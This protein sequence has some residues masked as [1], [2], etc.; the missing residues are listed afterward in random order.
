V[1]DA[2]PPP[3]QRPIAFEIARGRTAKHKKYAFTCDSGATISVCNRLDIF[4]TID[5]LSPKLRVKVANGSLVTPSCTGTVRLNMVD[6]HGTPYT[7]LHKNVHYSANFSSNLLSVHEMYKQHKISTVFRGS[8]A[9][10]TTPDDV[11]IPIDFTPNRQYIL[12]ANA[13]SIDGASAD[14]VHE[15][16]HK[17][18][19]H[20]GNGTMHRMGCV[21]PEL[22]KHSYDFSKCDACLKG[23][24]SKLPFSKRT[25]R[26]PDSSFR[27]VQ[28]E[29]VHTHFG[30]RISTDLCGPFPTRGTHGEKYAIVFHDSATS[31]LAVYFLIDKTKEAV[32]EAFQNF[33]RDHESQLPYG[34]KEFHSDNG[35]E[36]HNSDMHKFCEHICVRQSFSI[37]YESRQ[38][39]YAERA[40]RTMLR[41]TRIALADSGCPERFWPFAMQQA[42]LIHN[43][44][45]DDHCI[46]PYERVWGKR[47][48]Y[49]SL[50]TMF[51]LCYYLLPE[52]DRA[53]KFSPRSLPAIY[54][55]PDPQRQGHQ[56]YVPGL[57][58][59]TSAFHVVF[60]EHKYYDSTIDKTNVTFGDSVP[61]DTKQYNRDY[62]ETRDDDDSV[63]NDSEL[64]P[65]DDPQH[66]T[67]PQGT[68]PGT[69][70]PNHCSNSRCTYPRGHEGL[71]SHQQTRPTSNLRPRLESVYPTCETSACIFHH[72][73]CGECLN[74]DDKP[75]LVDSTRRPTIEK[76]SR[77]RGWADHDPD[78]V[79][80]LH[81]M[82]TM[83]IYTDDV[84]G[85]DTIT[86]NLADIH[87]H[88]PNKYEETQTSPLK[89]RW[90]ESMRI[91][92]EA[93]L[94]NK[95][96][97][98]VSRNDPRVRNRRPTKSRWV[99]AIKY[100]RDGT[101][102]RFKSRFV[103]CGYSQRQGVDY[104]RAF[105]ATL[106]ATSFRTLLA[107]ASGKKLRLMQI[108][109]SNAFTQ[110]NMDDADVYVEPPKGPYA[111]WETINGKRVSMLLYLKRALYGTKQASR[112]WQSA[113]REHLESQGFVASVAD[114]CLYR[115]CVGDEEIILGVYVDDIIVAYRGDKLYRE[116]STAFFKR[117]PGKSGPLTWFLGM[118]I[119]QHD[120]FSI[121]VNHEL[122]IDKM[123]EKYIPHNKVTREFPGLEIYSKLDKAQNDLDRAKAQKFAYSSIV[124]AL[125]YIAVMSHPE[126]C[127]HT[128]ILAKYL[129]DPSPQCCEAAVTLLQF[130]HSSRKK[131]LFY[132]GKIEVPDGL[133][134]HRKDIEQ[135]YGFV[136]FSDSSWGNKYPYP[137]FGYG[138]YLYG[139]LISYAS[140]QLKTVAFS[141][142]EAEYSAASFTCKEMEFVRN[143]CSDMG[144]PLRDR[145]VLGVDNTCAI[146]LSHDVGVSGRTKHF[147]RAIH[148][149]RQL[150]Q[151][152]RVLPFFVNTHQQR[153]DGYTKI[154][155]KSA[156][157]KWSAHLLH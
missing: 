66:G 13:V 115:K 150:T 90:D 91:E 143:I 77:A 72:E 21:I 117:F 112:L 97:E 94:K 105:S 52:R 98:F 125:L 39:P 130:L 87:D 126:I 38:N 46:S 120:D 113:L 75:I 123:A 54:L 57:E 95:T 157:T 111:V 137:M 88:V 65:V 128:S 154:L 146:D 83:R 18:L 41:P 78:S 85:G 26:L 20:Y 124:G 63:T 134:M 17:R 142:C 131:R 99:Y 81:P 32:I 153:A 5:D 107:V 68:D 53:S 19:M 56:V 139:G 69:W 148:Y 3:K 110:A 74:D 16:W 92:W 64:N 67:V 93:L 36:Y 71:C 76:A 62:R 1:A 151:F 2:T 106:R 103:V 6:A 37:P 4:E 129:A 30:Q 25:K 89:E 27:R 116:F 7:V 121:H 61:S 45:V 44:I 114:P 79:M 35:S 48:D 59:Q 24:M 104:D 31:Y 15:L 49:S 42:A 108:D 43:I 100:N 33:L 101:I 145:L 155:D 156:F 147:D 102:E 12:H 144:V 122:S 82:Q 96:F 152:K 55:G 127:V 9:F 47:Y 22:R 132:S 118:A 70:N 136:A 10:F 138:I 135:N 51:C 14:A 133:E 23:G 73:H 28:K 149:I 119:D 140:K 80:D 86:V 84:H 141:S 50:H 40:W 29:K 58:R 11:H 8:K 60:N 34:V 109:V